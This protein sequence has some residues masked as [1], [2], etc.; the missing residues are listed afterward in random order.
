MQN[1]KPLVVIP[2]CCVVMIVIWGC[3]SPSSNSSLSSLNLGLV[4]YY[5]FNGNANDE[6]GHGF[7]GTINGATLT[8]DRFDHSNKAYYFNGNSGISATVDTTLSLMQFTMSAWFESDS[9]TF[10]RIV[11]VT[12]PTQCNC[13][14]GILH[15][16]NNK[17]QIMLLTD[18][19]SSGGYRLIQSRS[20]PSAGSWH[21][22]A[23]TYSNGVL[24]IYFNGALDDSVSS[25]SPLET[26]FRS[27]AA[28]Q[29]GFC[30]VDNRFVGK[31]DNIRI[32]NRVLSDT[33]IASV[34]SLSD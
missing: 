26:K 7:N 30:P 19:A 15:D 27:S 28:L 12:R 33:E 17:L 5:P 9:A 32:Y 23:I 8:T 29:I 11:T 1:K 34:Y 24:K 21:H 13:Y 3:N 16:N 10:A 25:L 22:V 6:S 4:A 31:L 14:Y 18:S 20:I 2:F